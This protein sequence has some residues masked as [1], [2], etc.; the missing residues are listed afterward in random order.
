EFDKSVQLL[1]SLS[2]NCVCPNKMLLSMDLLQTFCD[3][4]QPNLIVLQNITFANSAYASE[5]LNRFSC[6][7]ILWTL[8]EP[9]IDGGRLRL[10]SLTG[11]YSAATALHAF[12]NNHFDY[13]FGSPEESE[14]QTKLSAAIGAVRVKCE[15]KHLK[16]AS[17]GHTP[18]GFGFGRALDADMLSVFGVTLD[19]I[20]ARELIEH[21]KSYTNEECRPYLDEA[22]AKTVG[23]DATP[24]KNVDDFA[25]LYKAYADYIKENGI[26]ALSSRCWPDFFTVYGTPV[27][28]VLSLLNENGI[29]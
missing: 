27:C 9:V 28:A 13:V 17:I 19:S 24:T 26:G 10:N 1:T 4:V 29:A 14:V 23:M 22:I 20:E 21:A 6:P 3:T 12:G 15:L 11:A 5:I 2:D 25:R 8:R 16:M 7:V 18:Q